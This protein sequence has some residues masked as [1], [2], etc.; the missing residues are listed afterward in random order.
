MNAGI[1][2]GYRIDAVQAIAK[3]AAVRHA[4]FS[5]RQALQLAQLGRNTAKLAT[6]QQQQQQHRVK[7]RDQCRPARHQSPMLQQQLES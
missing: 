1:K 2:C 5:L 3:L 6:W 7:R 4:K